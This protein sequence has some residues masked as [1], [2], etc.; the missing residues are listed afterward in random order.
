MNAIP[1]TP[2]PETI[3]EYIA[4]IAEPLGSI[5]AT[6]RAKFD[7]GLPGTTAQLWHGHPV[8]LAD[9]VPVAGFKAYANFVTLLLWRGQR[10]EDASGKLDA[11]GGAEMGSVKLRVA[12]DVD[13]ALF[14]DWL[15]Q[16][17]ELNAS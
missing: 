14:D 9:G 15:R 16:L 8:W 17:R 7:E 1:A 4:A 12:D 11:S 13:A 5:A 10:I 2:K 6:L 3:D